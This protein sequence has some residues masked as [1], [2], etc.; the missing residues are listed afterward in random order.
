MVPKKFIDPDFHSADQNIF[1]YSVKTCLFP[2]GQHSTAHLVQR[3]FPLQ[4][5]VNWMNDFSGPCHLHVTKDSLEKQLCLSKL[6]DICLTDFD[7]PT[8]P[9]NV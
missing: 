5:D 6:P 7:E 8:A 2:K 1:C 4:E 9:K 3:I